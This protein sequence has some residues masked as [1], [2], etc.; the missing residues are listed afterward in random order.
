MQR[1][2]LR[3]LAALIGAGVLATGGAAVAADRHL[4]DDLP[5]EAQ[6]EE[7]GTA[8]VSEDTDGTDEADGTDDVTADDIEIQADP[9][10]NDHGQAVSTFARETALEGRERGLAIAELGSSNAAADEA[11]VEEAEESD[12][13]EDDGSAE[14]P[15]TDDDADDA[16]G[17]DAE[18]DTDDTEE[19]PEGSSETSEEASADGRA[20]ADDS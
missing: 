10:A 4:P 7:T 12:A 19:Q 3:R 17:D 9:E 18:D 1:K 14:P 20:N 5:D 15:T 11:E 13:A 16:E 6:A 8:D 2:Q